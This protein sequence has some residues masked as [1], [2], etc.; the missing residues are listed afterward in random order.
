[1]SAKHLTESGWKDFAKGRDL[2]D[3]LMLKALALYGKSAAKGVWEQ[4]AA[5]DEVH[6]QSEALFKLAKADRDAQK[7]LA[8][9]QREI[10]AARATLDK[11]EKSEKAS[12]TKDDEDEGSPA[13]LGPKLLVQLKF[14]AANQGVGRPFVIGLADQKIAVLIHKSVIGPTQKKVVSEY[15]G[16]GSVRWY[17]GECRF[18]KNA[19][20]FL[21]DKSVGGLAAKLMRALAEQTGKKFKVRVRGSD[22]A[23]VDEDE[24]EEEEKDER[25]AGDKTSKPNTKIP[26]APPLPPKGPAVKKPLAQPRSDEQDPDELLQ[27]FIAQLTSLKP[28]ADKFKDIADAKAKALRLKL[29]EAAA[30]I[31]QKRVP[32]LGDVID[33]IE[34][35]LSQ[36][37]KSPTPSPSGEEPLAPQAKAATPLSPRARKLADALG[38][39]TP[40]L[41]AR[42]GAERTPQARKRVR[43]AVDHIHKQ[44]KQERLAGAE[45]ALRELM[46]Y[47]KTPV[48]DIVEDD[49]KA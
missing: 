43:E 29:S 24:A 22:P 32:M 42:I 36:L 12:A 46:R 44:I 40:R 6:K 4:R 25:D 20:A 27:Q 45:A 8:E 2:K 5:L 31:R 47:L 13:L 17:A 33:D 19:Y 3:A 1:M 39:L 35:L 37:E 18:E 48:K 15:L 49:G 28:R 11:V 38:A 7:Y 14:L 10:G 23:D 34:V 21:M 16:D 41:A 9:L 30:L 26:P